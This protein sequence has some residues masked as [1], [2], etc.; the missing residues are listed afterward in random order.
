MLMGWP[1]CWL[2]F[3]GFL[4]ASVYY[5]KLA[6]YWAKNIHCFA[7]H[8]WWTILSLDWVVCDLSVGKPVNH[9]ELKLSRNLRGINVTSLNAGIC[10]LI[11]PTLCP[12]FEMLGDNLWLI[13]EKHAPLHSCRVPIN[14]FDPWY[15][16]M[17]S[18]I[19]AAKIHWHW[20]DST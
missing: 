11:S 18:D 2:H 15:N 7:A 8:A 6:H 12:T 3:S 10:Q 1:L 20:A 4:S 13:L 5:W 16:A 19:T 9:A 17:K 14:Q